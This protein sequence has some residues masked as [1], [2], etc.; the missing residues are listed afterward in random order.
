MW[1]TLSLFHV[2]AGNLITSKDTLCSHLF[3]CH[4]LVVNA[5]PE[6]N[7]KQ[8]RLG[9]QILDFLTSG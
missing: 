2:M 7:T 3:C 9:Y 1:L 8:V 6:Q 5:I 4:V